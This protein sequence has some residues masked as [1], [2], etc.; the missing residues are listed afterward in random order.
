MIQISVDNKSLFIQEGLSV[1]EACVQNGIYIPNLCY[2]KTRKHPHAS[3]RLCFVEIEGMER[4]VT[5]CTETARN[6]MI[7]WT[8]T[9]KVRRLQ[10][11]AFKLLMS[12]HHQ[13]TKGC[14]LRGNCQLVRIAKHL[15]VGLNQRPFELIERDVP[16]K[17]DFTCFFYYPLRCVLCGR[18]VHICQDVTGHGLLTFAGR[19]F[20]T[21]IAFFGGKD[22]NTL[23]CHQCGACATVCPTAALVRK[24]KNV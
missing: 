15:K 22:P 1:L 8:A 13:D 12:A 7:V 14:P 24:P 11:T 2:V 21:M 5:S 23:L 6:G 16:E 9:E 10:R 3:C 17:I 4:P 18:C 20:D 19:S